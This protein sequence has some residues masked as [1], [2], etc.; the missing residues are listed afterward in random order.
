MTIHKE[1]FGTILVVLAFL[2]AVN[3]GIYFLAG[4]E[5][6]KFTSLASF[7]VF[8]LVLNFFRNPKRDAI[9]Q[10]GAIVAPADGKVVAIEEVE[11]D[12]YLK[13]KCLQVSIFMSV[14]NVHINWFPIKGIVK[15]FRHHNGRFMA[16][17]LPK[18]STENER[19]SVVIENEKG[20]QILVR[21]VAGA[22]ARRIVCYAEEETN[23]SQG[24]QMGF[25]K[26]GSRVDLYLPL[27]TR[28]DVKL[29]Q[30]VTGRQTILG[31]L[32]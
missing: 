22:M 26:F 12:E 24:Q 13:T 31:W 9:I 23:I 18:S 17:Y 8:A 3:T 27:D 30:K 28:I 29:E 20:T 32:K 5:V 1:G 10:D 14:F 11:E 16:A 21:Q 7:I 15:Y 6:T 4:V 19:T 25:I 2:L